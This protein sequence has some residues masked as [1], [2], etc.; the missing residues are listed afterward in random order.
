MS[1]TLHHTAAAR[2]GF[3]LSGPGHQLELARSVQALPRGGLD[4]LATRAAAFFAGYG[5]EGLRLAGALP[6]DRQAG[7]YLFAARPEDGAQAVSPAPRGDGSGAVSQQVL[8]REDP[9][10]AQYRAAVA[11]ALRRIAAGAF[12]KIVLSRSLR[13]SAGLAFDPGALLAAL[14][15]DP[16][17]TRFSVPLPPRQA[18]VPRRLI[19][20]T[21]ELLLAKQGAAI[22]SHPLAGS[23]PRGREAA[24]D[25]AA[26][27]ALLHS[28][29]DLR[30]HALVAEMVLDSL[31]PWCASLA[32]P[33]G[34][35]LAQTAR[36]WHLGTRITGV[37][38]D[39]DTPCAE[40]LR[41]LHPT[42]AV[43]GY[44]LAAAEAA[45]PGLEGYD[46]DF[47]AGAV[48]WLEANGDGAWYLALRCAELEGSE[49]RLY[50]GA[51][52][53]AGSDPALEEAETH[54]KFQAMLAGFGLATGAVL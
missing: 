18:G 34:V 29:K 2:D 13:L 48:G 45:L 11:E 31:A 50:A 26:G 49:A 3:Y 47:Y 28:G 24:P 20:A 37:L 25:K 42:P 53:V 14:A 44:P 22:T 30:E 10:A 1:M 39:P 52:V 35:S 12:D 9:P 32:R 15:V 51:G 21:P 33:E 8:L 40:L 27:A 36:L 19:G 41:V 46:R 17:I 5:T 54:A 6:Y 7:D 16:L 4:S 38:K 43:S 23:A